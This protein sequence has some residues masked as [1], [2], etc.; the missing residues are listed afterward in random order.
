MY[1]DNYYGGAKAPAPGPDTFPTTTDYPV[2]EVNL[3]APPYSPE[4]AAH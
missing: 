1:S 2:P 4:R 3:H